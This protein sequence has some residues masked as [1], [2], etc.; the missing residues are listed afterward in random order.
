[1]FNV[2]KDFNSSTILF[3]SCS[4]FINNLKPDNIFFQCAGISPAKAAK[5]LQITTMH[6]VIPEPLRMSHIIGSGL[7]FGES[8]GHA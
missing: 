3:K 1:M 5:V 4:S 2:F 6:G 8:R 7:Q